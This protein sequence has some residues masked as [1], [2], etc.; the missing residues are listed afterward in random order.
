MIERPPLK[1]PIA[2]RR[3]DAANPIRKRGV[4]VLATADVNALDREGV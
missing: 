3:R 4:L 1:E 2:P